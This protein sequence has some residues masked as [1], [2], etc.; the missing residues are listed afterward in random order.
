M[1][2]GRRVQPGIFVYSEASEQMETETW[3]FRFR[4]KILS[5]VDYLSDLNWLD[6]YWVVEELEC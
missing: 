1:F 5:S 4:L 6:R 3:A 2:V